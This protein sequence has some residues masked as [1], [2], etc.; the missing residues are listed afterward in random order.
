MLEFVYIAVLELRPTVEELQAAFAEVAYAAEDYHR[1]P[2]SWAGRGAHKYV[3][4]ELKS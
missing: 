2:A 3:S 4:T 1:N